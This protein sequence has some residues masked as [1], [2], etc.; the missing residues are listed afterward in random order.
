M[1]GAFLVGRR[2]LDQALIAN[3]ALVDY[4]LKKKEGVVLKFD[5]EKAYDHVDWGFLDKM[6]MK[7]GFAIRGGC[8]CGV[9]L[10]IR[11]I[12]FL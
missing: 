1:Q 5:F 12:L 10:G 8:G 3:E 11:N 9:V 4:R 6:L 7:K 2:I